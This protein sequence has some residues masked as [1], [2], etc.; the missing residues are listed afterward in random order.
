MK[1]SKRTLEVLKNFAGINPSIVF[2][3][4]NVISTLAAPSKKI[5][6]TATIAES[7]DRSFGIYELNRLLGVV[8][9]FADPEI[10]LQA[11]L[12]LI[13]SK[14]QSVQYTYCDPEMV[15]APTAKI[16]SLLNGDG[17]VSDASF[18]LTEKA[19]KEVQKAAGV[20]SLTT[21]EFV[22]DG[23]E[24][25]FQAVDPKNVNSHL[26]SLVLGPCDK[27]FKASF[28]S[29]VFK[30]L[31]GDYQVDLQ[32]TGTKLARFVGAD[33]KYLVAAEAK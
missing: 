9:L 10:T 19:L 8:S 5:V 1:L 27:E 12:M 29:E 23:D 15:I 30:L 21:L 22:S 17:Y 31:P 33:V 24:L 14:D 18:S 11:R 16:L 6:A 20:L 3:E 7:F 32:L 26:F 2:N 25:R 28:R 4:G 13:G